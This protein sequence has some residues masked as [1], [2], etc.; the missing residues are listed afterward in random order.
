MPP[1]SRSVSTCSMRS[2]SWTQTICER[3]SSRAP[4]L[5][6]ALGGC[7]AWPSDGFFDHHPFLRAQVA[8]TGG[9]LYWSVR[10]G[11]RPAD[12]AGRGVRG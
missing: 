4:K 8:A 5:R 3:Y 10:L 1:S 9:P 2:A 11:L 7:D 6:Q 12:A